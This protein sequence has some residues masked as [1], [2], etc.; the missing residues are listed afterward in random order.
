[1]FTVNVRDNE[2]RTFESPSKGQPLCSLSKW[3]RLRE[4]R[5]LT[6]TAC[7]HPV[8]VVEEEPIF[9]NYFQKYKVLN[10]LIG[11]GRMDSIMKVVLISLVGFIVSVAGQID[12]NPEH[13]LLKNTAGCELG[14]AP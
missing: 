11:K 13:C 12:G 7:R 9:D 4:A 10:G 8:R 14:R 5:W 2:G 3:V 6:N 1:M